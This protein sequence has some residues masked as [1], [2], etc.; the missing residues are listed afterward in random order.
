MWLALLFAVAAVPS[1]LAAQT[2][3]VQGRVVDAATGRSLSS[4][5]VSVPGT[6]VGGLTNA[7]GRFLLLNVPVGEQTIDVLLIGYGAQQQSVLVRAGEVSTVEFR[8]AS[9]ALEL[10]EVIVTGTAGGTQRRAIGNVVTAVNADQ[11]IA[12]SPIT[13]VDQLI[14]QRTPG[15]TMLPGTGQVGT[16]TA[17]A[18]RGV[19]SI[20]QGNDPIIYIDGVRM[21]SDPRR[22]PG[23]RG[24]SNVSRL[25][26]IHPADIESIEIIKGPAAATL[27]GT[28][29]SNGVIQIITKSGQTGAPQFD[30]TARVGTNWLWDP[31]G[32]TDMRWMPAPG[33]V[34]IPQSVDDLFGINVYTNDI[35]DGYGPAFQNGLT[36][37]YNLSVRG[38]TDAVRYFG[39]ISRDDDVG[40]VDWNWAKRLALRANFEAL[41]SEQVTVGVNTSYSQG[42]TRLAQG[43]INWDPF[44][45][46]IWSNPRTL[47]DNSGRRGWRAAPPEEWSKY[48]DRADNDRMTASVELR[49]QPAE[50]MTHRIVAGIDNNAEHDHR[51]LAR[52]PEGRNHYFGSAALGT[53]SVDR[54]TRRLTTV[55]YS[56]SVNLDWR[57]YTFTPSVG[58]QY[59]NTKSEFI[60]ADGTEFPAIPVTTVSGAAV[61]TSGESYSEEAMVGFYVQQQVGWR[62]RAFLTAA[63]RMDSHSAFGSEIDATYYPKVSGTWV[64]SEEDFWNVG[65]INQFRLRGAWGAAGQQPGTF[66]ASRLYGPAI[67]YG[68]NPSLSPDSYGNPDL[69]PERGEELE[70]GFDASFFD[71]RVTV[72][73]TRFDRVTKDAIVNRPLPPSS[74]FTGSQ[75]VNI[76]R[77]DAWGNELGVNARIIQGSAFSWDLDTQWATSRNEIIDLGELDV[78][79]AGTQTQHREGYSIADIFMK[80]VLEAQISPTGAVLSATCDGGTGP[81][82]VDPGGAPVPCSSA[83]QVWM[84][85]TQPTWQF[86]VGNTF[87]FFNNLRLYARVEGNG[88]HIQNNTEIRATH[89]QTTTIATNLRND[90]II[91]A[92]RS[93]E[94]DRMGLY[95]AGFLRLREVSLSYDLPGS[96]A[97]RIGARRGTF[98]VGM[99]NVAMLWT[100]E[101]GWGTP[102]S[103][104]V[105]EKLAGMHVWDPEVRAT[106]STATNYQTVLPPTAS[107]TMTLRLSF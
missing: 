77:I 6:G 95:E 10:D 94:N 26:D 34:G 75:V 54:G 48:E 5:Q 106:G 17:P 40:I 55:D 9:S 107:L 28:E 50:W 70:I 21:D 13:S 7:D 47:L 18:I 42:Q 35:E 68:D 92:Y 86:G 4:A 29:A 56:G 73:F 41:L 24:G 74:G 67:G 49:Y 32:R 71:D 25:N 11:V 69:K 93:L 1:A 102:R 31:E 97:E 27:Y 83:P 33:V 98:S 20:S 43:G 80:R 87:T 79:F 85:R 72:E 45:N 78:I 82:G 65:F 62:N 81:Q 99:R 14:G 8:M 64:L 16:G 52:Q 76:G 103:G 100:A 59:Y 63:L 19:A 84:G 44:S 66:A 3:T 105:T 88:G 89:N 37:S 46:L 15:L 2:G 101:E 30:F 22:G 23:Q 38:G 60:S 12:Q 57:E 51:T 104:L 53:K 61:R 36:Q 39:S 90:P 58:F 96:M 91:Q